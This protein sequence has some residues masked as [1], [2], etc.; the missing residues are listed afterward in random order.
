MV[1]SVIV[2][3]VTIAFRVEQAKIYRSSSLRYFVRNHH[4]S[5]IATRIQKDIQNMNRRNLMLALIGTT[6]S[7]ALNAVAQKTTTA[8][9]QDKVAVASNDVK[10][11]LLLMDADNNGKISK[12]EWMSFME[13]EFNQLDKEGKGELDLKELAQSRL[14]MKRG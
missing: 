13:A 8:K 3:G 5:P 12:K 1:W 9:P 6:G 2:T 14:V 7:V 11:L 10:E 4:I